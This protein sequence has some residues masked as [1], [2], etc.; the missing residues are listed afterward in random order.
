M[1]SYIVTCKEDASPEQVEEVK[2][3]TK[4]QGGKI[5]H[6]YSIIKGFSVTFDDDAVTTLENHPHVKN[7]E[8]D[9]VMR[10][11]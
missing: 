2:K 5:G 1:P 6:E 8:A 10:T 7:V 11:Q 4:E 9:G 3:H